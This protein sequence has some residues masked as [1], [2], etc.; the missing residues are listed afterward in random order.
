MNS[1]FEFLID[2]IILI[3]DILIKAENDFFHYY[4]IVKRDFPIVLDLLNYIIENLVILLKCF[5]VLFT[6]RF[7]LAWFPNINPFI[8]PY[9][10]I[11]VATQPYIDFVAKRIPRIF[12]QDISFF[13]CSFLLNYV[14]ETL[15]RLK[16]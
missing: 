10:V 5:N 14:L 6:M 12:G 16:F 4:I 11:R 13:V 8:A 2:G 9:Y 1:I 3:L 7:M 15:P